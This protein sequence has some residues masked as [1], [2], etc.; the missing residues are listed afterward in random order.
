M[1]MLSSL[2]CPGW[3]ES[4]P[5]CPTCY[6]QHLYSRITFKCWTSTKQISRF[7]WG[8]LTLSSSVLKQ[9][10][11]TCHLD[12][13]SWLNKLAERLTGP[14]CSSV[15]HRRGKSL[16]LLFFF[17]FQISEW[18]VRFHF[19]LP[20]CIWLS[21]TKPRGQQCSPSVSWSR[22]T[23]LPQGHASWRQSLVGSLAFLT[24]LSSFPGGDC[25]CKMV[26]PA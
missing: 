11:H 25:L 6:F 18:A 24:A 13:R 9:K 14:K 10:R 7:A 17:F 21:P 15:S 8:G 4:H 19:C 26:S 23:R 3:L 2:V 22:G 5:E 1:L 12:S 16:T 20:H